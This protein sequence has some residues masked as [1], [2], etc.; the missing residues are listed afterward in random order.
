[1][2]ADVTPATPGAGP[3][4]QTYS[5]GPK[6]VLIW[7][8][9]L[10]IVLVAWIFLPMLNGTRPKV[11]Q[12]PDTG[13]AT[14]RL[15]PQA[16]PKPEP[17]VVPAAAP[18]PIMNPVR[19]APVAE[20][21]ALSPVAVNIKDMMAAGPANEEA[22]GAA[23]ENGRAGG[24]ED[25]FAGLMH[26]SRTGGTSVARSMPHRKY[27]VP[28][29]TLIPCILDTA[30]NS[31]LMGYVRCHVTKDGVKGQDGTVML[32]DPGAQIFGEAKYAPKNHQSR[33]FILWTLLRNPDGV[34]ADLSSPAADELGRSGVTG[35]LDTLFWE[36]FGASL[37]FSL[38]EY[39]PL[40][41][42]QAL[43][44]LNRNS[45]GNNDVYTNTTFLSPQQAL[46]GSILQDILRMPPEITL[47]QGALVTVMLNEDVY[48]PMYDVRLQ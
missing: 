45:S 24:T 40:I 5:T 1:M 13:I 6:K 20:E 26:R 3:P 43:Q 44:N 17:H 4:S 15:F 29:G 25:E 32:I 33:L 28:T 36:K 46:T 22:R 30:V 42:A 10:A 2:P 27:T 38:I 23:G 12:S 35:G 41:A 19:T 11:Q 18:G 48:F 8:V 16:V 39:G 47:N 7:A 14:G 37:A 31:Q 21:E 34:T 9:I